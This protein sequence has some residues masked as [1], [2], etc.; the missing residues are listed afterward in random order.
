MNEESKRIKAFSFGGGVQSVAA[1]VLAAQG[2]IDYDTFLFSNV[3]DDSEYPETIKYFREFAVPYAEKNGLK[4]IELKKYY[5][6]GTTETLWQKLH[7]TEN[8]IDIPM[9]MP[10]GVPG[11]RSCTRDFKIRVISKWMVEN[12]ATKK[13]PGIVGI[14]ISV[15]EIRRMKPS[16]LKHLINDHP[17]IDLE[18]SRDDCEKIILSAGLPI[19]P[20]SSCF[21]CPLH[22]V[23]KWKELHETRP[24]L[25]SLCVD[26][27]KM[28][29]DRR[30]KNGKPPLYLMRYGKPLDEVFKSNYN[31]EE[32]K[33]DDNDDGQHSCGPFT[34][35]GGSGGDDSS[36][37]LII[38]GGKI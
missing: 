18:M 34:C 20:K 31:K 9:R 7:R 22:S 32:L 10:S 37:G 19:P 17:L 3:G 2:E 33:V 27:E 4:L 1:L 15:D 12:G 25:F 28:I 11:R 29:N 35:D 13:N 14:G 21:F 23:K 5:S 8:S 16:Q 6:D 38:K 24:E 30:S 26:L 36:D